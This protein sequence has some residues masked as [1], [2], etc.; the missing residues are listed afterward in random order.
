[1]KIPLGLFLAAGLA[2]ASPPAISPAAGLR[3]SA[4]ELARIAAGEVVVRLEPAPGGGPRQ[5][6]GAA[7]IDQPPARVFAALTDFAHWSEFM[8][9]MTRSEA[10]READGSVLCAQALALP[11]GERHYLARAVSRIEGTGERTAWQVTWSYLPGSGNITAQRGSWTLT[12]FEA[13]HGAGRTLAVLHLASDPG[14]VS[15]WLADRVTAKSIPW[16]FN[17][18][19]Q[20]VRRDRYSPA[21][22]G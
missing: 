13:G 4:D 18:L 5:G 20:H 10:R 17:G 12:T 9:F 21:R 7:T 16:I 6:V 8:P 22:P 11:S 19:R 2:V 14:G 3:L 1:L 15:G